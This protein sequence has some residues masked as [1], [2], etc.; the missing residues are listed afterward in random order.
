MYTV[1][2]TF[3][4]TTTNE[5]NFIHYYASTYMWTFVNAITRLTTKLLLYI[6]SHKVYSQHK[7]PGYVFFT[8]ICEKTTCKLGCSCCCWNK[9]VKLPYW[10]SHVYATVAVAMPHVYA[11]AVVVHSK[12]PPS[13]TYGRQ[14]QWIGYRYC[15]MANTLN[16]CLYLAWRS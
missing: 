6:A 12:A 1:Y 3:N 15:S 16:Y 14:V 11:T 2:N 10:N 4:K 5:F 13:C 8:A 9:R 7:H